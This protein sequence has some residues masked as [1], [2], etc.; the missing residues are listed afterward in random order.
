M[1]AAI[2]R[3]RIAHKKALELLHEDVCDIYKLESV[4]D[5]ATKI[6]KQ[7]PVIAWEQ[8]PCKL[9]FE[10]LDA[11]TMGDGAAEKKISIKLFLSA[12]IE[13]KE[14]SKIVVQH[15][16]EETAYQRSG[17]PAIHA[18]HQEIMLEPFE[19]WG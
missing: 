5:E 13:V 10:S 14:G 12:D 8:V 6:T 1:K 16:G 4:R 2:Q 17:V 3:A 15:Q 11:V 19:R 18:T 7:R 9:S